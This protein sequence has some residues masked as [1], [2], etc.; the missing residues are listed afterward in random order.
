METR[1]AVNIVA[2]F[3]AGGADA[4][5]LGRMFA[6]R[7]IARMTYDQRIAAEHD[8]VLSF[9]GF[10]FISSVWLSFMFRRRA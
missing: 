4:Y 2:T 3:V 1:T 10:L 6:S 8:I 9:V 5:L 7:D